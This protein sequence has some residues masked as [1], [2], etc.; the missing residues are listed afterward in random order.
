MLPR[1]ALT[2]AE[3]KKEEEIIIVCVC[4]CV[5]AFA[6]WTET[7]E[8]GSAKMDGVTPGFVKKKKEKRHTGATRALFG[9]GA[10]VYTA[11]Q[12]P[13]EAPRRR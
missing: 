11:E 8:Q 6:H 12:K 7:S 10:C 4:V 13:T 9:D 3:K 2:E 1:D 5:C